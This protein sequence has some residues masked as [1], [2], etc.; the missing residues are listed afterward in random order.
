M[1]ERSEY[2]SER[3][4]VGERG[5][6]GVLESSAEFWES[7]V[8]AYA[9]DPLGVGTLPKDALLVNP[10]PCAA[11]CSLSLLFRS[12]RSFTCSRSFGGAKLQLPWVMWYFSPLACLYDLLQFG[13]GQRKGLD[14]SRDVGGRGREAACEWALEVPCESCAGALE[15]EG[16]GEGRGLQGAVCACGFSSDSLFFPLI[17]SPLP[18]SSAGGT[19]PAPS[20][21][22]ICCGSWIHTCA[23]SLLIALASSTVAAL[24]CAPGMLLE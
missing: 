17:S 8:G 21:P 2:V 15:P 23:F 5:V 20:M 11:C 6:P 12:K 24:N 10:A 19:Q 14:I 1:F 22:F 4:E 7:G 18:N 13:L 9:D 3:M 16:C